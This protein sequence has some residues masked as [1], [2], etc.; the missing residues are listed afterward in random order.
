MGHLICTLEFFN[1]D[2]GHFNESGSSEKQH[3]VGSLKTCKVAFLDR[4]CTRSFPTIHLTCLMNHTYDVVFIYNTQSFF[5][6]DINTFIQ[7]RR[8]SVTAKTF[9]MLQK[10]SHIS[11][12]CSKTPEKVYHCFHKSIKYKLLIMIRNVS[13]AANQ[14]IRMIS[15]GACETEDWS[16]DAVNSA[17]HHRK[18]YILK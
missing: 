17:L 9:K 16:N 12:N 4:S 2:M 1:Y 11:Q 5:F 18:K 6:K 14:W 7:R 10:I 13:W 3:L 8:I 15:E